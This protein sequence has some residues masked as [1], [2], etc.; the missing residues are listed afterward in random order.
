MGQNITIKIAGTEYSL[1]AATPEMEQLERLAAE[2]INRKLEEYNKT[3]PGRKLED[4][5]AIVALTEA[6]RRISCQKRISSLEQEAE[7]LRSETE[8]YLEP[9]KK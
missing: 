3:Q 5:L 8:K 4:K 1:V 2:S 6:V 7:Q 9:L